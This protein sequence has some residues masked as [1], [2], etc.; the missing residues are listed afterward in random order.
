MKLLRGM[1]LF[2][3]LGYALC[4]TASGSGHK[5]K[6]RDITAKEA[7]VK[8]Q[9][10]YKISLKARKGMKIKVKVKSKVKVKKNKFAIKSESYSQSLT[11]KI[12]TKNPDIRPEY[13]HLDERL[14]WEQYVWDGWVDSFNSL[15]ADELL[16]Q[17]EFTLEKVVHTKKEGKPRLQ[18]IFIST[19][20][21]DDKSEVK[22]MVDPET[23]VPWEIEHR[24]LKPYKRA[25]VKLIEYELRCTLQPED[26]LWLITQAEENYE[27]K[28]FPEGLVSVEHSYSV[29]IKSAKPGN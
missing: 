4:L 18:L 29:T 26:N 14:K 20:K 27:Y 11:K 2:C 24:L 17:K 3:F 8:F 28:D 23:F 9:E 25:G 21:S 13:F 22:V 1:I 6:N 12:K 5:A 10:A 16:N 19:R 7:R 15:E